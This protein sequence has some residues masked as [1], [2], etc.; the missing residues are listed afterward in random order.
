MR[1]NGVITMEYVETYGGHEVF[2]LGQELAGFCEGA[3]VAC[4]SSFES[5]DD[6]HYSIDEC[7][8]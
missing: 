1:R 4:C 5:M 2:V 6:I 3:Q 7:N 8:K